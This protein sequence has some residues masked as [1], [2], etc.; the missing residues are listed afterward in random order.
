MMRLPHPLV[1]AVFLSLGLPH[2]A[3][4]ESVIATR[5]IRAKS[6]LAATDL[7]QVAADIP[8]A[9]T[10]VTEAIGQ[11]ARVTLYPGRP[12]HAADIG[13]AAIVERNQIVSLHYRNAGL[14]I[15]TEGRAMERGGEGDVVRVM[16]LASRNAVFGR[17]AA[18]G[19]VHVG[20][21]PEG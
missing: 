9:L 10:N 3:L 17:I 6:V 19:N 20:P 5:V 18:D 7:A 15:V 11:E 16:N 21:T 1:F 12:V 14:L 13:P 4:A 2:P 8:G